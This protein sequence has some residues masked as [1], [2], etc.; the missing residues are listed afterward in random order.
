MTGE[1][2]A[3]SGERC[4]CGRQTVSVFIRDDGSEVGY[5]GLPDG[6]DRHRQPWGDP[7]PCPQYRL[8]PQA[9]EEPSGAS[10]DEDIAAWITLPGGGVQFLPPDTP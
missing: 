1:R 7:A 5:C 2:A 10:V 3:Q 9:Q 4:T 8:R 6:G